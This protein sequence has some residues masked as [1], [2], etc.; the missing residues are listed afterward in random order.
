MPKLNITFLPPRHGW[1]PV[2]MTLNGHVVE[3]MAS[4]GPNNPVK[5]L[6]KAVTTCL[7]GEKGS[8]WWHLE[9]DGYFFELS[10][11]ADTFYLRVL[12]ADYSLFSPKKE[13]ALLRGSAGDIIQP[14]LQALRD[15]KALPI[16]LPHWRY[17][18]LDE[19]DGLER[20]MLQS[21][22]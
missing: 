8:V 10:R 18:E 20:A 4:H 7:D 15:F 19:I 17:T 2:K 22:Y 5:E 6:Y 12:R 13:V 21:I 14:L 16:E 9:P 11:L 1:L 3:F